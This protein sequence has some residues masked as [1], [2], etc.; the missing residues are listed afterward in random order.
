MKI[1]QIIPATP[2]MYAEYEGLDKSIYT[3]PVLVFAL[4]DDGGIQRVQ[5]LEYDPQYGVGTFNISTEK[6]PLFK[7]YVLKDY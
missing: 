4:V 1:L 6:T 7:R 5:P 3:F 2:G